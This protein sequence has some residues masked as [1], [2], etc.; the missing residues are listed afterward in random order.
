MLGGREVAPEWLNCQKNL[1][2][3]T[4]IVKGTNRT[5][6]DILERNQRDQS[7]FEIAVTLDNNVVIASIK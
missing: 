4:N 1:V 3:I 7:R 6:N 5:P 2:N